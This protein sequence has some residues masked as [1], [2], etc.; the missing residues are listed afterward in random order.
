MYKTGAS[1]IGK[2]YKQQ[3]IL[4][5]PPERIIG[6]LYQGLETY[7]LQA[8]AAIDRQDVA[9]SGEAIS[10]AQG[11]VWELLGALNMEKG[12]AV[13]QNLSRLYRFMIN[14]L[15]DA[16]LRKRNEPLDEVL[17]VLADIKEGWN[18]ILGQRKPNHGV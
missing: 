1:N 10:R 9:R 16:S 12:E 2:A 7:L 8:K 14:R 15:L 13:A 11:I 5:A 17:R 6:Y 18:E 4:T 3:E